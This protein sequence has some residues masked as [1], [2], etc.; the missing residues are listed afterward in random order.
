VGFLFAPTVFHFV[1]PLLVWGF[2]VGC[3]FGLGLRGHMRVQAQILATERIEVMTVRI[4]IVQTFPTGVTTRSRLRKL[5]KKMLHL[6]HLREQGSPDR[7]GEEDLVQA[8]NRTPN[9]PEE[10]WEK[11]GYQWAG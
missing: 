11:G 10:F 3:C 8:L 7:F 2:F 1:F 4:Q 5:K 9:V 6:Q